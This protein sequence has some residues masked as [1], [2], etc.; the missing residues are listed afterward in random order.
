MADSDLYALC[1][2]FLDLGISILGQDAPGRRYVSHTA[3][4]W[5]CEQIVVHAGPIQASKSSAPDYGQPKGPVFPTLGLTYTIVRCWPGPDTDGNAPDGDL[6][7]QYAHALTIDAW[8]LWNGLRAGLRG[9]AP[10]FLDG[11]PCRG[12]TLGDATPQPPSG[13]F[14][15][16]TIDVRV[17]VHG[18]AT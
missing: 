14:A 1:R 7:D 8:R 9:E 2:A 3:P 6:L 17:E 10:A 15:A 5:D 13:G 18:Y 11:F 16:W 12:A 4:P